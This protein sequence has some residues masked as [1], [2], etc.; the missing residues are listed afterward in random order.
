MYLQISQHI[1]YI[2]QRIYKYIVIYSPHNADII[3]TI[4]TPMALHIVLYGLKR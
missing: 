1:Y 3:N 2:R 4:L